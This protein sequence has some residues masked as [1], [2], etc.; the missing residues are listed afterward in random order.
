ML[1]MLVLSFVMVAGSWLHIAG[2]M[3]RLVQAGLAG[4]SEGQASESSSVNSLD[5]AAG[6]AKCQRPCSRS[7]SPIP[8]SAERSGP[9]CASYPAMNW[10][11]HFMSAVGIQHS[12]LQ[13][14]LEK[15]L[16]T[17]LNYE[18]NKVAPSQ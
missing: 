15:P 10:A 5:F 1:Q 7:R 13:Q 16:A 6:F 2:A 8:R 3:W 9:E 18:L 17:R 11:S 12:A 14:Q 4:Q